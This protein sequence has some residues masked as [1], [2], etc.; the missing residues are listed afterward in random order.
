MPRPPPLPRHGPERPFSARS[1]S[2]PLSPGWPARQRHCAGVRAASAGR[3]GESGEKAVCNCTA[4]APRAVLGDV[5]TLRLTLTRAALARLPLKA[6]L[7]PRSVR[8]LIPDVP[9]SV[10]SSFPG[11]VPAVRSARRP[12]PGLPGVSSPQGDGPDSP[13]PNSWGACLVLPAASLTTGWR[14]PGYH[15]RHSPRLHGRR[16]LFL[17]V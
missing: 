15:A 5:H 13:V 4:P 6:S 12:R 2:R 11:A 3:P 17:D 7:R 10:L 9:H 14:G 1:R 16:S 8:S